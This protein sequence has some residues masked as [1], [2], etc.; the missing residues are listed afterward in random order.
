MNSSNDPKVIA[1]HGEDIYQTKYKVEYEV[2]HPG[3]FVAIDIETE[4]SYIADSPTEALELA[5]KDSPKGLFH[6]IKVGSLGAF[7]VSYTSSATTD[8]LFR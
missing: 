8:W 7:K 3:K 5:R 2:K 4:K 6:L 1:E